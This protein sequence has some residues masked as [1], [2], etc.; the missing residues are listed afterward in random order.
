MHS[1]DL[2]AETGLQRCD[3]LVLGL[4]RVQSRDLELSDGPTASHEVR[5]EDELVRDDAAAGD[6]ELVVAVVH[7]VVQ[8]VDPHKHHVG[9]SLQRHQARDLKG[10]RCEEISDREEKNKSIIRLQ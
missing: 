3:V 4:L 2:R 1:V 6:E 7:D 9:V 8:S 5:V 10:Q